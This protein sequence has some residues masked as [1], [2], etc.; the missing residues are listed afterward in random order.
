MPPPSWTPNAT[1]KQS[2]PNPFA[3]LMQTMVSPFFSEGSVD[4]R[5]VR[6]WKREGLHHHPTRKRADFRKVLHDEN[7]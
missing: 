2:G 6:Q 5:K 1:G 4:N 7:T 3:L